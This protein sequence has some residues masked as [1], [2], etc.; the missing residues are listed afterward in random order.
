VYEFIDYY[1]DSTKMTAMMRT[2]AFPTSI[3]AQMLAKNIIEQRG[4]LPP[5]VCVPGKLM[6][7]ELG[8]RNL[9]ITKRVTETWS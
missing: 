6:I 8:K 1:D 5:E 2:T 7:E 4:V 9:K 3:I